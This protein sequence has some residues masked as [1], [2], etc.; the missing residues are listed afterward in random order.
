MPIDLP[1]TAAGLKALSER[2]DHVRSW[3][4]WLHYCVTSQSKFTELFEQRGREWWLNW[5]NG[6]KTTL[7]YIQP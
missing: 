1:N 4:G 6:N 2:C 3:I 7:P 5:P